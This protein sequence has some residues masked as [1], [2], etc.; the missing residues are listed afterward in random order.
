M[1]E[2]ERL[3]LIES[4]TQANPMSLSSDI[5]KNIYQE[6]PKLK[7]YDYR[8]IVDPSLLGEQGNIEFY[9]AGTSPNPKGLAMSLPPVSQNNPTIVLK[10]LESNPNLEERLLGDMLHELPKKDETFANLKKEFQENMTND[11][12]EKDIIAYNKSIL[13]SSAGPYSYG[14]KRSF[15]D[16]NEQSRSDA[17][18]RGYI[19]N[20]WDKKIYTKKQKEILEKIKKYLQGN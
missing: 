18:I 3:M 8:A 12:K 1:T 7:D 10:S 17:Y 9:S 11:Q 19:A 16:W 14:E 2:E 13:P 20:Q 5:F 6:Y 4:L 15:E